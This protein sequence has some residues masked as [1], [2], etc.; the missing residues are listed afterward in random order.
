MTK[1]EIKALESELSPMMTTLLEKS[2]G[3]IVGREVAKQSKSIVQNLAVQRAMFGK[4]MTGLSTE[5]KQQFVQICQAARGI[6]TK[7][8]EALI[9][10]QD[11]RGGY[12]VPTEVA[13]A[14]LRIAASVG[15][16]LNQ[17]Q[18]WPMTTDELDIPAYTGSFLEGDYLA[19]D[20]AGPA[21]A[22]TFNQA[23]LIAKKWQLVFV[24]GN[25]LLADAEA[26]LADWL[27]AL[28]AEA[29]A[30]RV[31][32]EGL[33]GSGTPFVGILNHKSVP[34]YSL[35]TGETGFASFRAMED[36]GDVIAQLEESV[37]EGSGFYMHRTVWSKIRTQKAANGNYILPML[38]AASNSV[39]E[40][41]PMGPGGKV[42]VGEL[43]GYPVFTTRHLPAYSASAV[44]TPF[45]VFGN[46]KA[47]AFGKRGNMTL[48]DFRTGAFGGKEIGLADQRALVL[49]QRHALTVALPSAF[50]KVA[51][52]AS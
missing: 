27:L 29:L 13:D 52:S 1:E 7:A 26:N 21:T 9:L 15:I 43:M 5:Q 45:M 20:A 49:K 10:E 2:I 6:R 48:E 8:N 14:I 44:S 17:A 19:T 24:V 3:D 51:T 31:D 39:L 28:A 25:D 42:P 38:G 22:L 50:V 34:T 11:N 4:D 16:V 33:A 32:K 23:R 30:N 18:E 35:P 47:L 36:T 12:L 41:N 40:H 37:L 46:L